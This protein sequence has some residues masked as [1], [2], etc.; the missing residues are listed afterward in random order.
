MVKIEME[1]VNIVGQQMK[2]FCVSAGPAPRCSTSKPACCNSKHFYLG[3]QWN[4]AQDHGPLYPD[5]RPERISRLLTEARP[6][7]G[8]CKASWGVNQQTE[9]LACSPSVSPSVLPQV[10]LPFK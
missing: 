3:R 10:V 4:L 2:S 5:G 7:H 6:S 1:E 8:H 9:A